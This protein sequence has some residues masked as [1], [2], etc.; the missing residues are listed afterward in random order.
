MHTPP[1]AL[2]KSGHLKLTG[3]AGVPARKRAH[4]ANFHLATM[5]FIETE[6]LVLLTSPLKLIAGGDARDPSSL[7]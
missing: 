3:N 7:L 6:I 4:S 1:F 2:I 5:R